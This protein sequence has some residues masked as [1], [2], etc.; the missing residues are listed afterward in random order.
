MQRYKLRLLIA[1]LTFCAGITVVEA[2]RF[3]HQV[4]DA[5][6][7]HFYSVRQTDINS[8]DASNG[9]SESNE[10]YNAILREKFPL[11]SEFRLLVVESE[12]TGC[13]MYEDEAFQK[14]F[15]REGPFNKSVR[16]LIPEADLDTVNNYLAANE[17]SGSLMLSAPDLNIALVFTPDVDLEHIG[18][19]WFEFYRKYPNSYGLISFSEVGFN[20][21]HDQAFVYVAHSCGGTCGAGDYVLLAKTNGKWV[22][23]RDEVLWVS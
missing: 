12:T 10:V 8:I 15:G 1:F 3:L 14:D 17:V 11:N 18:S 9:F 7:D 23:L 4:E 16:G 6:V 2:V 20:E 13:P 21:R 22:I 19:F 5:I